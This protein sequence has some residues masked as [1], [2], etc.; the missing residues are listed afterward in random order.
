V[1]GR[2]YSDSFATDKTEAFIV[3]EAF[4][5]SMG[6]KSALGKNIELGRK[7]RII[8]IVKDYSYKSLHNVIEPL[9]LV[10]NANPFFNTTSIRIN[11]KD[12]RIVEALY[13]KHFP[14]L[15]FDYAFFDDMLNRY[16]RQDEITMSLFNQFTI[17]AI[18]VSCLGLYGLVSL[19]T[20]QRTKE[21]G[22]RKVLGA[23]ISQLFSLLSRDFLILI[24]IA[25]VIA[26]PLMG[27]AMH[28][29]LISYPYHIS[30]NWMMF[31]VPVVTTIL[32]ALAVISREIIKASLVNPVKSLKTE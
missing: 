26:I 28:N 25:M 23:T 11:P 6:W 4:V 1:E 17:L 13:K 7:G 30:L 8:G 2:N 20:V 16:Y 22:V 10:Y 27:F 5:R 24:V 3:N 14:S 18:F 19:V 32:I 29:W 9:V 21:I 31:V 15:Y 12:F